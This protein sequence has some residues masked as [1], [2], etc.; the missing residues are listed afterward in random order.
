MF[1][2][3]YFPR[4][5]RRLISLRTF[6]G[7]PS[8]PSWIFTFFIATTVS[9]FRSRALYTVAYA[10]ENNNVQFEFSKL[11]HNPIQKLGSSSDECKIPSHGMKE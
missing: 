8:S 9:V 2:W 10:P 3:L 1:G 4:C 6:M 7:T 5:L 11:S